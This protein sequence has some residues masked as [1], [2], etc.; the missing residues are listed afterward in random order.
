MSTALLYLLFGFFFNVANLPPISGS[1][2][3]VKIST[4]TARAN[5]I[6]IITPSANTNSVMFGD[7]TTTATTGLPIAP[8]GGYNTPTCANCLY[9]PAAHF[10]YVSSGDKAYAA[11]GN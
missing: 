11:F 7:S 2:A 3:T 1:N 5:W 4:S 10:V 6:Q 8:G 9:T